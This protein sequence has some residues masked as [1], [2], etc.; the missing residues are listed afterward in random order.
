[1]AIIRQSLDKVMRDGGT[2]EQCTF[3]ASDML[4][5]GSW[6]AMSLRVS[7]SAGALLRHRS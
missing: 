2:L 4:A 6:S 1:M 7:G 3:K 5:N